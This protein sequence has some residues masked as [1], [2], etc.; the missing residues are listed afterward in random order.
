[1]L[2]ATVRVGGCG[3]SCGDRCRVCPCELGRWRAETCCARCR[4]LLR[5]RTRHARPPPPCLT[6][7]YALPVRYQRKRV[8]SSPIPPHAVKSDVRHR[9]PGHA[10]CGQSIK[11]R[12]HEGSYRQ[13]RRG[14]RRSDRS[15]GRCVA[16]AGDS[17][18]RQ[19]PRVLLTSPR[20]V[21][22]RS[23]TKHCRCQPPP[24]ARR[25][26]PFEEAGHGARPRERGHRVTWAQP[27][28]SG[29]ASGRRG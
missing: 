9:T 16:R 23:S 1:M 4:T 18:L 2:R 27:P 10:S 21:Y 19:G 22:T 13:T 25:R 17:K 20:L 3:V 8:L 14:V 24:R 29:C 12:I 26:R 15:P 6:K 5:S 7:N 11:R 28:A